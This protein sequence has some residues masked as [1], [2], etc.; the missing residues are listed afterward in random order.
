MWDNFKELQ[1]SDEDQLYW[2]IHCM[3]E[4]IVWTLK[5]A[6]A[7]FQSLCAQGVH[8]DPTLFRFS[9]IGISVR[10]WLAQY[11]YTPIKTTKDLQN[12]HSKNVPFQNGGQK[13][14]FYFAVIVKWPNHFPKGNFHEDL[15]QSR[16]KLIHLHFK[17]RFEKKKLFCLKN[18]GKNE[19]CNIAQ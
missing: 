9:P 2:P 8:L 13:T 4:V 3:L 16:R 5:S 11:L 14:N 15:T 12:D 1:L 7:T 19:F 18:G 6:W 17:I 10:N